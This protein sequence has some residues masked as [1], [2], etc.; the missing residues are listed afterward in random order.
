MRAVLGIDAAWTMAQPSGVAL[1]V[2]A[3]SGWGLRAVAASYDGFLA[4]ADPDI[5][6]GT[7]PVGSAPRPSALLNAAFLLAGRPVD[8]VAVD[9][10]LS[11]KPIAGR[12]ASDDMVSQ[13]YGARKCGTHTPGTERPGP[14]GRELTSDFGAI[15]Y[16]LQTLSIAAPGLIEVYPHPALVELTS[17]SERLPYKIAKVRSYWPSASPAERRT[18][19]YRQWTEIVSALDRRIVGLADSLP[20]LAPYASVREMK[21]YEDKLD[22]V[23]CAWV[24]ICA[25]DGLASPYGDEDSA[26]WIPDPA[27]CTSAAAI[28]ARVHSVR[29]PPQVSRP[30]SP[31]RTE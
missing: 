22:A 21:A 17:A 24:A 15:G 11:R 12:R 10:P 5:T 18:L 14:I 8:L 16:P 20:G 6:P 4:L 29:P 9:M 1:A 31:P 3:E 19:L 7:Q 23:V 25:L 2:E 13:A 30:V 26:I 28:A 27:S